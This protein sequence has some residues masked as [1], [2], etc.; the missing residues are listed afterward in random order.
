MQFGKTMEGRI[1]ISSNGTGTFSP[2][3]YNLLVQGTI[4]I[5]VCN[6]DLCPTRKQWWVK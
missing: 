5:G 2:F 6:T 1:W 3:G 4:W